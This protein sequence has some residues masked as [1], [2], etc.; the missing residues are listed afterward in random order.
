VGR[1]PENVVSEIRDRA[2]I[3]SVVGRHVT[4]KKVG[5]RFWGLCPFHDE[6]TASFQ[7]H[8]DK[9]IFYCFG[10]GAGGDVF[11]FRMRMEGLDFPDVLRVLAREHGIAIPETGGGDEGQAAA[12]FRAN[13]AAA[14]F[15]RNALKGPDGAAARRYLHDRGVPDDL[16]ERFRIGWAP[17]AWDGLIQHLRRSRI[18]VEE[19][20]LAGLVARR[21]SGDGHYDRFRA[22]VVFPILEPAGQIAGFGGRGMGSEPPKY[23]NSPESPVYKKSRA[24]FG[25]PQALE[26]IRE[27]GRVIVVEGYF[28]LLAL[29]RAGLAEGVAPCG[30][31][32]TQAHARR[33]RRYAGE[34]VLLFDGDAAGQT[35]AERALPILLA[36]GLRV[37]AAFLPLGEDPDTLVAK[38]GLP[39][40]R[41]CVESAVPLLDHL[42]ERALKEGAG[43]AWAA[44]DTA[45]SVA[46]YLRALADPVERA[47]Y[48]RLLSSRLEIPPSALDEALRQG[49]ER[50]SARATSVEPTVRPSRKSNE[51]S[52][53]VRM[54]I[55]TL[56]SHPELLPEFDALESD[57][58]P[59]D[60]GAELLERL[61]AACASGG[62]SGAASLVSP[63]AQELDQEQ[64]NLLNQI[65]TEAPALDAKSAA[66]SV[67][68]CLAKL[69]I[70]ALTAAKHEL[71]ERRGSCTDPA[72]QN[73]IDEELQRI[74]SRRHDL[75]KKVRQV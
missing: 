72:G 24:L 56:A 75:Q 27:R 18:S 63:E 1:I 10:C 74:T 23:L 59:N 14:I 36:E 67:S 29:H 32:L 2:D 34:V 47:A 52:P 17:D 6:K 44:A 15:F 62:R 9:Q 66:R 31:A 64:K 35:A 42:I 68:D 60:A 22:R 20:E 61:Q 57:W 53:I 37:R 73:E 39:A 55:A 33:I 49:A 13:E 65:L 21:P 7:V 71:E 19:A 16:A 45:R 46:P 43:H 3:V 50:E 12:A 28:D 25:L 5:S 8:A 69:E 70:G 30:T 40:L 54:L 4:L 51:V 48:T 41:S 58:L 26:A 11:A 38:S